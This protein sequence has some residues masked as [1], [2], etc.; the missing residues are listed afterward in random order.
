MSLI[1]PTMKFKLKNVFLQIAMVLL[2]QITSNE[3]NPTNMRSSVGGFP[4][5]LPQERQNTPPHRDRWLHLDGKR[6]AH[7]Q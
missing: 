7:L 1:D 5:L 6:A 3:E 4:L 2:Q